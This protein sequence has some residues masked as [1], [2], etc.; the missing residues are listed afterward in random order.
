MAGWKGEILIEKIHDILV[1]A[2]YLE[3]GLLQQAM[4]GL[5][6]EGSHFST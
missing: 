5:P 3:H 2:H 1:T 4:Y 6:Q